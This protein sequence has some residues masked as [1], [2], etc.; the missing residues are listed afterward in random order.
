MIT[1]NKYPE[2]VSLAGNDIIIKATGT[3]M[4]SENG[5][6]SRL[7]A[8]FTAG[9]TVSN[10]TQFTLSW[11]SQTITIKFKSVPD[12]SGY[13]FWS[14]ASINSDWMNRFYSFLQ[15]IYILDKDFELVCS[16]SP[17]YIITIQSRVKD[18]IFTIAV[19]DNTVS[20]VTFVNQSGVSP[21]IRTGYQLIF[22]VKNSDTNVIL[23]EEAITPD[24]YQKA[25]INIAEYLMNAI[26]MSRSQERGFTFPAVS[27]KMF[28]HASHSL[29]YFVRYAEKWD[30]QVRGLASTI[31]RIAFAGG[32]SKLKA[33][34]FEDYG[35]SF[36]GM[37]EEESFFLTWQPVAKRTSLSSPERLYF[38]NVMA[39]QIYLR[40][41]VYFYDNTTSDVL[42]DQISGSANSIYELDTSPAIFPRPVSPIEKYEIWVSNAALDVLSE[43][44]TYNMN[45]TYYRNEQFFLF[46]NSLGGYDTARFTGRLKRQPEIEREIFM[47][48]DNERSQLSNL[49]DAVYVS[50]SGSIP[51]DHARWLE[52]MMMSRE[53]YWL[54]NSRA[55]PIIVS[56]KKL[57]PVTDDQRRF[58]LTFDFSVATIENYYSTPKGRSVI[59]GEIG[60][61]NNN[62]VIDA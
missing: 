27:E 62:S 7:L 51:G 61:N 9:A 57:D 39:Q 17:S 13:Q 10:G 16:T 21:I 56:N 42:I 37:L 35:S 45:Y 43:V 15:Q 38:F 58:N 29:N 28:L 3:N 5:R 6:V 49:M 40:A 32:L 33:S 24:Q 25:E 8:Y 55:I 11:G 14:V 12:N 1:I 48:E 19:T 31:S 54:L 22:Q 34:E 47:N 2:Q 46:R 23:G 4:Y 41:K 59:T 30:L 52:D 26:E 18:A 44:R 36:N 50:E 60:N 20:A 53:V